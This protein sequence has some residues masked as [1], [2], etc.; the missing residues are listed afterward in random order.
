[1]SADDQPG[2]PPTCWCRFS[3]PSHPLLTNPCHKQR[4]VYKHLKLQVLLERKEPRG[5]I[6]AQTVPFI[7]LS[8]P[9]CYL[10]S[11]I[12][13]GRH[14]KRQRNTSV[15]TPAAWAGFL[16]HTACRGQTWLC[17]IPPARL[18]HKPEPTRPCPQGR[19]AVPSTKP[20]T[21]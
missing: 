4:S 14:I 2:C 17:L 6:P 11:Y 3:F 7:L 10:C 19:L 21:L 9:G 18:E 20:D 12:L 8:N 15:V 1:M 5:P 13:E 16:P